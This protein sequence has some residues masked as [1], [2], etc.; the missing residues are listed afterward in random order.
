MPSQ[1]LEGRNFI[2]KRNQAY[3]LLDKWGNIIYTEVETMTTGVRTIPLMFNTIIE[4][5]EYRNRFLAGAR[6][7]KVTLFIDKIIKTIKRARTKSAT[8]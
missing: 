5:R 4:A 3:V 1:K 2:L 7:A 8:N 6:I